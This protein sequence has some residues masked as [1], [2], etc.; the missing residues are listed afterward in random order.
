MA[1]VRELVLDAWSGLSF[2][3]GVRNLELSGGARDWRAPTWVGEQNERRLAAY[4]VL[5][6]LFRNCG[7][8][9]L[10]T[11]DDN[12]RGDHREYGDANLLVQVVLS[13]VLGDDVSLVV[14]GAD[15]SENSAAVRRQQELDDWADTERLR[16]KIMEVERDAQK[17]GDGVYVLGISPKKKRVRLRIYDPG[18]YFPDLDPNA[19]EDEF[20]T[21]VHIAWEFDDKADRVRKIRRITWELADLPEGATQRLPWNDEATTTTC[22]M[23]DGVWRLEDVARFDVESFPLDRGS[24]YLTATAEGPQEIRLLDLGIDFLP[25]VHLPN[26]VELKEHF[27]EALITSVAQIIEDLSAADTDAAKAAQLAGVPM[28]G[29]KDGGVTGET[30]IKVRPGSVVGGELYPIDMSAGL[31]AI[32]RYV[33]VLRDRLN[34]NVRVP[35]EVVGRVTAS[36]DRSGIALAVGSAPHLAPDR[37]SNARRRGHPRR[38]GR[39]GTGPGRGRRHR[40]G[41]CPARRHRGRLRRCLRPSAPH[42]ARRPGARAGDRHRRHAG[43]QPARPAASGRWPPVTST[44]PA[45]PDRGSAGRSAVRCRPNAA[46]SRPRTSAGP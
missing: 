8:E 34:E 1:T 39:R 20:P 7:R 30:T 22:Y 12:V 14:E 16:A 13:A 3:R 11:D 41:R 17:L 29:V 46:P 44:R 5:Y 2:K 42:P 10:N 24:F 32:M 4:K 15:E 21:R 27:G 33:G 36:Q 45:A 26:T 6:A 31:D 9:F 43:D 35:A 23:T 37:H 40:D 25:V 38:R 19:A 18:F 28:L